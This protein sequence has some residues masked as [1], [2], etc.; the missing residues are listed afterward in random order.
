MSSLTIDKLTISGTEYPGSQSGS[1]RENVKPGTHALS[2]RN[3]KLFS[4]AYGKE[5]ES[6]VGESSTAG[7]VTL[8]DD[9]W[10]TPARRRPGPA[11]QAGM[12]YVAYDAQ[13]NAHPRV[14]APTT[15]TGSDMGSSR[16]L[17]KG[18]QFQPSGKRGG[19]AKV[20]VR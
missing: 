12:A 8:D 20:K 18:P 7:G 16:G 11:S 15:M 10:I 9:G 5:T 19:F 14:R 3:V 17:R 1:A 2:G 6:T 4:D 13:G